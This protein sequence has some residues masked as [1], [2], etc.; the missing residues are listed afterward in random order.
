MLYRSSFL[1]SLAFTCV[2][3]MF[4]AHAA[5][6]SVVI[7][8]RPGPAGPAGALAAEQIRHWTFIKPLTVLDHDPATLPA[9]ASLVVEL[10]EDFD[11]RAEMP[12]SNGATIQ[13]RSPQQQLATAER[14]ARSAA[15][16]VNA[17][18]AEQTEKFIVETKTD[19]TLAAPRIT[20]ITST[21]TEIDRQRIAKRTRQLRIAAHAILAGDGAIDPNQS[22]EAITAPKA[23]GV[24]RVAL[25]DDIGARNRTAAC[26]PVWIRQTLRSLNDMDVYLISA[27]DIRSGVLNGQ[28]DVLVM[29]GGSSKTQAKTL[30]EGGKRA[31]V[32]YVDQGGGYVGVCAGAFLAARNSFGLQLLPVRTKPTGKGGLATLH[33]TDESRTASAL[34]ASDV[35]VAFH[36]G[37]VMILAEDAAQADTTVWATFARDIPIDS[38]N[39]GDEDA[40][41]S[42]DNS[43]KVIAVA[44]TPAVVSATYG[45]GRV[46]II[47]PHPERAPGPQSLY[48]TAIRFAGGQSAEQQ[49]EAAAQSTGVVQVDGA[50]R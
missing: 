38:K 1:Q 46:I 6:A 42:N 8:A 2:A 14:L 28:F 41:G 13:V 19:D 26:N 20:V 27:E 36:G 17:S 18:I 12:M 11:F 43:S 50:H 25:Y 7:I 10:T 30:G 16:V 15:D 4:W 24:L 5:C 40:E 48:W 44:G 9:D 37:P 29:G 21:K 33:L 47:G 39:G 45:K 22:A 49:K 32:Q 34:P 23:A 31:I 3:V 35:N